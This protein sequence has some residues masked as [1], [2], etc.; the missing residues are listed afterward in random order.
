MTLMEVADGT[1]KPRTFGAGSSLFSPSPDGRYVY[2][3]EGVF[4]SQFKKLYLDRRVQPVQPSR[5][6]PRSRATCSCNWRRT[7]AQGGS[8]ATR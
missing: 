8:P 6:S 2:C 4:N 3:G 1:A 5:S 7:R